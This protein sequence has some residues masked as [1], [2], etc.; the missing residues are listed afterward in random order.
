MTDITIDAPFD[1]EVTKRQRVCP[2]CANP[3]AIVLENDVQPPDKP[4]EAWAMVLCCGT[5]DPTRWRWCRKLGEVALPSQGLRVSY[6]RRHDSVLVE[7]DRRR[8]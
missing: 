7:R 8:R 6:D 4:V 2:D 1:E 5:E 3:D